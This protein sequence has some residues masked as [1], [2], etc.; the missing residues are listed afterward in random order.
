M[1]PL[2]IILIFVGYAGLLFLMAYIADRRAA[3][4]RSIVKNPLI[5][6]LSLAV[7]CTAWTFYGSVGRASEAGIGFLPIY[8]GP[9]IFAPLW[10]LVLRK[11]ILVSKNQ[12]I[13]SVV[14][15]LSA[16]YGK[17]TWLGVLGTVVVVVGIIPYISIQLKAIWLSVQHLA[18]GRQSSFFL[19]E[20][21][22]IYLDFGLYLAVTLA[23]FSILF[24]TRNL[25]PNERH[26][27]LV[28]AV[29]FESILKLGAFLAV[30]LFVTF[31]LYG[32]FGDLFRQAWTHEEIRGLLDLERTGVNGW[33]WFWLSLLSF[34][35]VLLL[36]RQF[37]L[38]VV[39][40]TSDEHISRA[41]WMFPL[42]LLLINIFVLP[43]A[44]AGKMLIPAETSLPDLYVLDLPLQHGE[45]LLALFAALGG[46][47]A[48]ASMVIVS[49]LALSITISNNMVAP[50]LVHTSTVR[51]G[52]AEDLPKRLLAIRRLSIVIVMLLAYGYFKWIG[53]QY[54]LVSV[55]LISFAAVAQFAPPIFI[56]LYWKR[57]TRL[58]AMAGLGVGFLVWFYTLVL[59]TLAE[60]HLVGTGVVE[61][62]LFRIHW[63]RPG[64][65]FGL[66]GMDAVTHAAFWSLLLNAGTLAAVSLFTRQNALEITQADLFVDIYKYRMGSADYDVIRR[67]ARLADVR[68]LLHR[69]LGEGRGERILQAYALRN[70]KD[71]DKHPI[72]DADLIN[73]AETH[74]AGALGAASA[75][76]MMR[77]IATE[78]PISLEEMMRVLEQTQEIVRYS[79]ELSAANERL[80][81][82]DRLKA[83][84]ITTVTHELRTPITSIKALSAIL[85]DN[86]GL[87]Q[88]QRQEFLDI[89]VSESERISR[90][91]NQ[92]LDL[93]KT[94][95]GAA[96]WKA[97]PVELEA[98]IRQSCSGF[99]QLMEEKGIALDFTL[100]GRPVWVEA[101]HDP[102]MQV[103]VNLLSNAVK[104]C[105]SPGGQICLS[106]EVRNGIAIA[107]VR[108]NGRGIAPGDQELIFGQFT[109]LSHGNQGKPTGSG[110]GLYISKRIV[111][112]YGGRIR[113]ESRPGEG[114][115]FFVELKEFTPEP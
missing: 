81:E 43:I 61:N 92:V 29:A 77:S 17:S 8:L 53:Q 59:P 9:A 44:F 105:Q 91:I 42:Y 55:G 62:G 34:F 96:E 99:K 33:S 111:E 109:Q 10:W 90:L 70:R 101:S 21:Q 37:H 76:L 80:K 38:A 13:T 56:G 35:A 97:E 50:L 49:T 78:D 47:S 36:P 54:T 89:I 41:A 71:L 26:E 24:G 108:D 40:N 72:A 6:S 74:L 18:A 64:A 32:G 65:L 75:K 83:D 114:A 84:F 30:G 45:S 48:G 20:E 5:Y 88:A 98:L 82:L 19:L 69:F 57:A 15:F 87:P 79:R 67:Q 63:L 28:A 110:L 22:P 52:W 102:L 31:G 86:A 1:N 12:R 113:L 66:D 14:D 11:V 27:G 23:L 3:A 112:R 85:R 93:E 100:P 58:G 115:A 95:S 51:R 2:A 16:R 104:F 60:V 39:E 106:L 94:Q 107:C 68:L 4:G 73:Y 46:F 25:D 103:F 7:Y